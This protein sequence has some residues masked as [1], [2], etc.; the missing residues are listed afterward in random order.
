MD[1]VDLLDAE[2]DVVTSINVANLVSARDYVARLTGTGAVES[3]PDEIVRAGEVILVDMPADTLRRRLASGR[4][5]SAEQVGGALSEY[6]RVSNLEALSELARSWVSG[7]LEEVG[8]DLLARR[9]LGPV[10]PRHAIVAGVSDSPW[11]EAVVLRSAQLACDE[12]ADLVVLHVQEADGGVTR[13]PELLD[14]YRQLAEGLGGSYVEVVAESPARAL[15][16]EVEARS[17]S[18]VVV[19]RHRSALHEAL[20]G[21]V[22]RRL[23][24]L[25]PDLPIEEV[26]DRTV[27]VPDP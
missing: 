7:S 11:G 1:V 8:D 22:S 14:Y 25:L 19:A 17:A 2:I 21:S 9:G 13:H 23:H 18:T 6:F 5:F 15:A 20:V 26:R 27:A 24:R 4:V 3:V 16:R 12:D 10:M